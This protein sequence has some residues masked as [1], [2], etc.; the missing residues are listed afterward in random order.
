SEPYGRG[1]VR[2]P[3]RRPPHRPG[4]DR[5]RGAGRT[6]GGGD[7]AERGLRGRGFVPGRAP[8]QGPDP[9]SGVG[10]PHARRP[11]EGGPGVRRH[12]AR[13]EP[14]AQPR[15]AFSGY[16]SEHELLLVQLGD[17]LSKVA[18]PHRCDDELPAEVRMNLWQLGFP[19]SELTSR[20]ELIAR[21]WARKRRVLTAMQPEWGGMREGASSTC[22]TRGGA[23]SATGTSSTGWPA[24]RE[25]CRGSGAACRAT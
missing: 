14:V 2:H 15:K 17:A 20:E 3:A 6:D 13:G 12:A 11:G 18:R 21:L 5:R 9:G 23:R 7:A 22:T 16:M 4:D 8:G 24:L 1:G 25:C 10:R 19:C